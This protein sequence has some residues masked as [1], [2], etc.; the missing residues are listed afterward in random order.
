MAYSMETM[1]FIE[2]PTFTRLVTSLLTDDEYG[3][4]QVDLS[5]NPELGDLIKGGGGIR[6]VRC[7]AQGRG[8]S[9]GARVIYYWLKD[10][11][12]IYMLLVYPKSKK[13]TLT[14]R[15]TAILR[16]LVKEL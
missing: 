8:K 3:D 5:E 15:E 4:L 1:E 2:T 7:A 11:H 9:G 14:D 10:D 16:E 6:K 13:D 12:Q